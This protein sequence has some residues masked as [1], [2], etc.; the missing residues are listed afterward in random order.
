MSGRLLTRRQVLVSAGGAAVLAACGGG[1]GGGDGSTQATVSTDAGKPA[2]LMPFFATGEGG[3]P[4]VLRT[5]TEQRVPWGLADADGAPI[6]DNVPERVDFVLTLASA[7]VG[8]PI[9]VERRG[10][11]V[12]FPYFP[13]R[14]NVAQPGT[15]T[16][17]VTIDGTAFSRSFVVAEPSSVRLVQR[18]EK[19]IP[20]ETPTSDNARGVEK[21]CTR[22]PAC[23]FHATTLSAALGSGKPTAFLVSTPAF[24]Q[25]NVCG[26]VLESLVEAAKARPG[27]NVVHAEVYQ[28]FD[29]ANPSASTL[30]DAVQRYGLT[31]EPSLLLIDGGG[32]AVD[33]L[34]FTWDSVE[35]NQALDLL[36]TS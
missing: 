32:V 20:V 14:F 17:T 16:A 29:S 4:P 2:F 12:P 36:K 30:T 35:L 9:S 15:Y 7:T 18:G 34:D 19:A 11:G 6:H 5:G 33:R 1:G 23:P 26:P 22:E 28:H 21:V 8:S 27:I 3:E 25:T 31:Y 10:T 24:C 13:L